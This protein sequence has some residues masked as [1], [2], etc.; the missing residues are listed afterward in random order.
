MNTQASGITLTSQMIKAKAIQLS[1]FDDFI[2]SK[3]WFE[4]Y[5]NKYGIVI[6]R[7]NIRKSSQS[8]LNEIKESSQS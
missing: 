4:K 2:A 8:L 3:G 6:E 1:K 5:K 7:K